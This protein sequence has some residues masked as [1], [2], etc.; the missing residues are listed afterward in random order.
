M[1]NPLTRKNSQNNSRKDLRAKKLRLSADFDYSKSFSFNPAKKNPLIVADS[2]KSM[3]KVSN[4]N[5]LS[6]LLIDQQSS[7]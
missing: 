4:K 7:S 6:N 3:I 5:I 1:S 2:S